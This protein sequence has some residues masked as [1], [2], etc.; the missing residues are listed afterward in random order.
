[1]KKQN[2]SL[3]NILVR[4]RTYRTL[5]RSVKK[6][7]AHQEIIKKQDKAFD[8]LYNAGLNKQQKLIVDR[9]ISLTNE[10]G[11]SYGS[12]AYELG[13]RDGIRLMSEVRKIK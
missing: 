5:D 10:W 12:I 13:L 4:V 6:N 2:N 7:K 8:A 1:M 9:A 11:A 3:L